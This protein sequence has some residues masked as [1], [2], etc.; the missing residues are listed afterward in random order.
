DPRVDDLP[1]CADEPLGDGGL[2]HEE[3]AGDLRSRKAGHRAQRQGDLRLAR[4]RG[5]AAR[6]DELATLVG[7]CRAR[8]THRWL[9]QLRELFLVALLPPQPVDAFATRRGQEPGAGI[10]RNA[11]ARPVFERGNERVLNAFLSEVEVAKP[12]TC[13]FDSTN[14]PSDTRIVPFTRRT[15]VV[16]SVGCSSTPPLRMPFRSRSSD[17]RV[18]SAYT[19]AT[20]SFERSRKDSSL[21]NINTYVAIFVS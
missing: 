8:R 13:S 19:S 10:V 3:R 11:F 15:V 16:V 9:L 6:E 20:S 18:M 1:L 7:E 14:G 12:P 2:G 17:Q 5:V 21:T 4:E